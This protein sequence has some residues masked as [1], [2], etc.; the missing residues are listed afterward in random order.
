MPQLHSLSVESLNPDSLFLEGHSW[1]RILPSNLYSFRFDFTMTLPLKPDPVQLLPTFQSQFWISRGWFVQCHL[2]DRGRYFRL[3][4]IQSPIIHILYWPDDEILLGNPM[5]RTYPHVN[6]VELWW[7]L[8]KSTNAICPHIRSI[9]LYGMVDEDNQSIDPNICEFLQCQSLEHLIINNEY[10]ITQT[11]FG[12]VLLQS[13]DHLHTLTC[14]TSWLQTLLEEKD[15]HWISSLI[16]LRIKKFILIDD[17]TILSQQNLHDF[18]RIFLHL[19][20][21]TISFPSEKHFF[22]LLNTLK[23]LTLIN[24]QLTNHTLTNRTDLTTWIEQNTQLRDFTL[25]KQM[26]TVIRCQ[27]SLWI[28]LNH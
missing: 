5:T 21:L 23:Q 18:S 27:I 7:N 9:Q 28:G 4:T 13:S 25:R 22:F 11:R 20:Q 17:E 12:S 24:I 15:H 8:S 19:Q 1:E 10:P 26:L 2:R 14:S 3:S 6:H 16:S